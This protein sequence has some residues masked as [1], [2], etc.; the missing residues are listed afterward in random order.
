MSGLPITHRGAASGG[1]FDGLT[2]HAAAGV[3]DHALRLLRRHV[4]SPARVL[5]V[6]CGSG[7]LAARLDAAGYDVLA[8]DLDTSDYAARPPHLRWDVAGPDIPGELRDAFD[9]VCAIEVLEHVESPLQALRNVHAVLRPSGLLV[10]STPNVGHP[11]SRLKFLLRGAPSYFGPAEYVDTGHRTLLPDWLLR[12]HLEATDFTV[13]EVSY[14][15][16]FGLRG[17][18]RWA[19]RATVPLFRV[20]RAMPEPRT[21]D[22]MATFVVA[23]RS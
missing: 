1:E 16:S 3:H 20:L 13:V 15:G 23:R 8:T 21:G 4:P 14:G 6:G 2:I 19:Y 9:A 12:R 11:R 10:A 5:D 22:G 7:A 17:L 18:G